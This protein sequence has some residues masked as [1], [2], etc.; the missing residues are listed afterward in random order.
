MVVRGGGGGG[1]CVCMC[2]Y[3]YKIFDWTTLDEEISSVIV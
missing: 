2:M 1:L 3:V